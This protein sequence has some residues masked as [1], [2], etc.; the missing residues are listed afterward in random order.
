VIEVGGDST[1]MSAIRRAGILAVAPAGGRLASSDAIPADQIVE[2]I[3]GLYE[4]Y[5]AAPPRWVTTLAGD[6]LR[7]AA[8]NT[9]VVLM[10]TEVEGDD[11]RFVDLEDGLARF[12]PREAVSVRVEHRLHLAVPYVRRIFQ[13]GR[14][15]GSTGQGAYV[16]VSAQSTLVNFGIEPTLPPRPSLPRINP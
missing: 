15:D 16:N 6:R 3:R 7:Y 8:A 2:G 14:H 13:D 5:G 4:G 11:V 10:R 12:G 9:R 1:K